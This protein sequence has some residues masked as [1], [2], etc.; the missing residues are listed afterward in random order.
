M[1]PVKNKTFKKNIFQKIEWILKGFILGS[2]S[3]LPGVSVGTLAL[4]MG[5]YEKCFFSITNLTRLSRK[6]KDDIVFLLFLGAGILLAIFS[7]TKVISQLLTHF[8]LEV[9]SVFSGLIV[10]SLPKLFQLTDKKISSFLLILLTTASIFILLKMIPSVSHSSPSLLL[11]FISGFLGFFASI[12]PGLSGSMVLW[13][14]GTY[15]FILNALTDWLMKYILM[16][17]TGG[18]LGLLCAFYFIR[19][20]LK[21]RKNIFFCMAI[22]CITGSLPEVI[23]YENLVSLEKSLEIINCIAFFCIGGGLFFLAEKLSA[24]SKKKSTTH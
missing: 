5:I 15:S 24:F 1:K 14:L 9:Y 12:L 13:L 17:L 4:I 6:N 8:P 21:K 23:P 11:F 19:F 20:F 18:G 16:F 3:L 22:G 2:A 10:A 7:L